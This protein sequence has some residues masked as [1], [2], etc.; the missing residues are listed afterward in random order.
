MQQTQYGQNQLPNIPMEGDG[1]EVG[2][3]EDENALIDNNDV[4]GNKMDLN[5]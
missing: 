5:Q 2:E 3:Q 1:I 4:E